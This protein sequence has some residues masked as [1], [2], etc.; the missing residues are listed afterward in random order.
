MAISNNTELQSAI[1][2]WLNRS[3]LT[4]VIPDFISLAESEFNRRIR[5]ADNETRT[6]LTVS[7]GVAALP[8][9]FAQIKSISDN[10][11]YLV[12]R[13]AEEFAAYEQVGANARIYTLQGTNIRTRTAQ[14]NLTLV[15][16]AQIPALS[17][18]NPTNWLLT[19]SPNLY[20]FTSLGYAADYLHD[21][22]LLTK[23]RGIAEGQFSQL[24]R[25]EFMRAGP[26]E[27]RAA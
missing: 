21:D 22:N 4:G 6:T 10:L 11:G 5:L 12:H 14:G 15:Y 18:S 9:D 3:D 8:S 19:K 27:V 7:S 26:M 20:L 17:G 24:K 25:D 16:W 2:S 1:A 13:N 23:Y